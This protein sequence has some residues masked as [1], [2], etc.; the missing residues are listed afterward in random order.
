MVE[1]SDLIGQLKV[2]V[3]VFEA[4]LLLSVGLLCVQDA[5]SYPLFLLDY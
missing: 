2:N 5:F 1:E 4:G 3:A